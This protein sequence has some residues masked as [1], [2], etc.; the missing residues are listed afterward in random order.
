MSVLKIVGYEED[1]NLR[2]LSWNQ[3]VLDREAA[4]HKLGHCDAVVYCNKGKDR[5]RLIAM[6]YGMAVLMLPPID[7]ADK[8]SLYLKINQLLRK[9][10]AGLSLRNKLDEEIDAARVRVTRVAQK[11]KLV[12]SAAQRRPK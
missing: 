9:F 6:F 11:A 2:M 1:T 12:T 7:P 4:K 5:I 8:I 10:D 3:V